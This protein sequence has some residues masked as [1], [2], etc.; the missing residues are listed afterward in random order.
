MITSNSAPAPYVPDGL[1]AIK[2]NN[3]VQITIRNTDVRPIHLPKGQPITGITVHLL[4]K[5]Y[6]EEI[7]ISKDTLRAYFLSNEIAEEGNNPTQN[8]RDS[9]LKGDTPKQHLEKIQASL[10]HVTSLLEASGLD[11][12]GNKREAITRPLTRK[13]QDST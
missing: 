11:P 3:T 5:E 1:Y 4:D 8:G 2:D 12:P 10:Q 7:P 6:Y 13:E 9:T